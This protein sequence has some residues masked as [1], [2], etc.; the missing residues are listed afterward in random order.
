MWGVP[1]FG[2]AV[3]AAKKQESVKRKIFLNK[4]IFSV[5]IFILSFM[6]LKFTDSISQAPQG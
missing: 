3:S 2:I 5:F 6:V 1:V 4:N